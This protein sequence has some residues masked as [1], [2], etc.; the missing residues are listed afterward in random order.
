MGRTLI[1][2]T[3][4]GA[5]VV[6]TRIAQEIGIAMRKSMMNVI[7]TWVESCRGIE[8]W[9]EL[10]V[11]HHREIQRPKHQPH[12]GDQAAKSFSI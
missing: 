5:E 4:V 11:H 8:K 6:K 2:S 7:H 10:P 12:V 9:W 3:D 1:E